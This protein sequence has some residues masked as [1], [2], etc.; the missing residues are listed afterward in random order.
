MSTEPAAYP[1]VRSTSPEDSP[2]EEES[3]HEEVIEMQTAVRSEERRHPRAWFY[4]ITAGVGV[5]VGAASDTTSLGI[6]MILMGLSLIMAPPRFKLMGLASGALLALALLP[7]V[8]LL[9]VS[10]FGP[11]PEWRALLVNEWSVKL[12]GTYTPELMTTLEGWLIMLCG[13]VWLWSALGQNLS[14][15]GRRLMLRI[16]AF[17]GVLVAALSLLDFWRVLPLPWWS[18]NDANEP[19]LGLGPFANHNHAS[20]FFAM[21]SVLAAAAALDAFKRGSRLW[22]VF[23]AGVL[24]QLMAILSNTSRAGFAL[25]LLGMTFWL[26]VAAMKRGFFRKMTVSA[27][28]IVTITS[29][30]LVAGGQLGNRLASRPLAEAVGSDLRWW[31]AEE[32]AI[33]TAQAPWLGFGLGSFERVFPL[34]SK[35][36]YPDARPLHPESDVLWLLFEGGLLLLVPAAVFVFWFLRSSGPWFS[37]RKKKSHESR[38]ARRIRKAFAIAAMLALIH[39]LI[40]VPLHGFS[41]FAVFAVMLAQSI[42]PRY[43]G[44]LIQPMQAW[45]FRLAGVLVLSFGVYWLA[46][47]SHWTDRGMDTATYQMHERAVL[48]SNAGRRAEALALI[49]RAIMITPLEFRWYYLRAQL[50]LAMGHDPQLALLDFGRARN[51]EPRF[52]TMCMD[53]GQF[54]L[55]YDPNLAVIAWREGMRRYPPEFSNA[56]P[57]Y[58]N[59]VIAAQA[60]PEIMPAIWKLADRTSLQLI[61]LSS[62]VV[63]EELWKQ[64]LGEFLAAHPAMSGVSPA[65]ARYF[66]NLWQIKGDVAELVAYL[67]NNADSQ[68]HAWRVLAKDLAQ[69]GKFEE[70]YRLAARHLPSPARSASLTGA[71][72]PRL[73]RAYLLSPVDP[74]PGV[75]LYYAQRSAGDMKSARRTLDK[76]MTLPAVPDFLMRESASL[77]AETGDMRAA[78]DAI[79]KVIEATPPD[80]SIVDEEP[81]E[82]KPLDKANIPQAPPPRAEYE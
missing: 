78:W 75:E 52:A 79:L 12:S 29:V 20:S 2:R 82:T 68:S 73:E 45:I 18:R 44:G 62:N 71:D 38:A 32:T 9:P 76:V 21:G 67:K 81:T 54:W 7:G 31:L 8:G 50:H 65:Q 77:H 57:R 47:A 37:R 25:F 64:C 10:W 80:M 59:I 66:F 36:P 26:A 23:A 30:V 27:A 74:L 53:E 14:D 24:L 46:L 63:R 48:E 40:E 15:D 70:A 3:L 55:H 56:L 1:E 58:Q 11:L 13:I 51:I 34:V 41:Y 28:L 60:Y 16:L 4:G 43:M 42:R 6:L 39:A 72:V 49:N 35:A 69:S 5:V 61:F 17:A 22:L 19:S 33:A